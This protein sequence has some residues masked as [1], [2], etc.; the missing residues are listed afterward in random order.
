[1][2][3]QSVFAGLG[4]LSFQPEFF[5]GIFTGKY[6]VNSLL[7]FYFHV[8]IITHLASVWE[9]CFFW[10]GPFFAYIL[11]QIAGPDQRFKFFFRKMAVK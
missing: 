6:Q 4:R 8:I 10:F 5:R 1:M 11:L 2:R 3:R 9:S 7:T